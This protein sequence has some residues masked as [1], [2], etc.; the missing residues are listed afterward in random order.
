M[1]NRADAIAILRQARE[2][3]ARRLTERVLELEDELLDDARGLTYFGEIE[4]VYEQ[5]AVRLSHVNAMLNHLP[6][7]E[8]SR[9]RASRVHPTLAMRS[10]HVAGRHSLRARSRPSGGS[11]RLAG[12]RYADGAAWRSRPS[13]PW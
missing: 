13:R 12:G 1:N 5:V 9:S 7:E 10:A 4:T 8:E 2:I 3:L 6:A 11:R